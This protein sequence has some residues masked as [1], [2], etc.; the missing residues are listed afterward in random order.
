MKQY[1]KRFYFYGKTVPELL[2]KIN[3]FT[4]EYSV[5]NIFDV[6]IME[7]L[8]KQIERDEK[9]F[10]EEGRVDESDRIKISTFEYSYYAIVLILIEE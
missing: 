6:S 4:K 8:D 2:D 10:N 5:G 9:K 1:H 3:E 7:V